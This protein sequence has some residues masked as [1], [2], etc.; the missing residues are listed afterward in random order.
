MSNE[1]NNT[2][3]AREVVTQS[4]LSDKSKVVAALLS[5]FLGALGIHRFYLGRIGSGIVMLVLNAIGWLTTG[6]IIGFGILAFVEI[7]ALIDFIRI[8]CNGLSDSQGR[9][10]KLQYTINLVMCNFIR[11]RL[12]IDSCLKRVI[13]C[14]VLIFIL[15]GEWYDFRSAYACTD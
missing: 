3:T 10:L 14:R 2:G 1:F 4:T 13:F 15:V 11:T 5:F 7:W 12:K 8:L 6:L 9:K